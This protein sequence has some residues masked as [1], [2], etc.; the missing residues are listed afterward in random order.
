MTLGGASLAETATPALG[1]GTTSTGQRAS[2]RT[3]AV[4][5]PARRLYSAP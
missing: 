5:L 4:T 1:A 3:A 2:F